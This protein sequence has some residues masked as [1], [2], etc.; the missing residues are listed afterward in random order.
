M[1]L[2]QGTLYMNVKIAEDDEVH[3]EVHDDSLSQLFQVERERESTCYILNLIAHF[4]LNLHF[5]IN[6]RV[7]LT[8]ISHAFYAVK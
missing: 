2:V 5:L 3:Y 6:L 1:Y 8:D 7:I 4:N